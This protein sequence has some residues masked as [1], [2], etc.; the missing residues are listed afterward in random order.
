MHEK[1]TKYLHSQFLRVGR[2]MSQE[3]KSILLKMNDQ[4][5][6][7]GDSLSAGRLETLEPSSHGNGTHM[8]EKLDRNQTW[9]NIAKAWG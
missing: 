4:S 2:M 5:P 7:F 8:E 3:P 1:N 9:H 6:H